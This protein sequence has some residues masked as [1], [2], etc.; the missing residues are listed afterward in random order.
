[1]RSVLAVLGGYAVFAVCAILTFRLS[2]HQPHADAS[3]TFK[4]FAILLGTAAA[5]IGGCV[6]AGLAKRSP[7]GHAGALAILL[8][9]IA[10]V[11]L[12]TS[13]PK[14]AIWTQIAALLIMAPAALLGGVL[15]SLQ[16]DGR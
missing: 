6:T 10:A 15:W 12:H 8:A 11:S 5:M 9:A 13:P 4:T 16:G 2:G 3:A 14:S 7:V 1:M